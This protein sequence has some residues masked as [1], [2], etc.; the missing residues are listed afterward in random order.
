[1]STYGHPPEPRKQNAVVAPRCRHDQLKPYAI[2]EKYST[3]IAA[4]LTNHGTDGNEGAQ[5]DSEDSDVTDYPEANN[6][7]IGIRL[8]A[9]NERLQFV[10]VTFAPIV[11]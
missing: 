7:G 4:F 3:S 5:I 2:A 11:I 9:M 6:K 1:M 8:S 10:A